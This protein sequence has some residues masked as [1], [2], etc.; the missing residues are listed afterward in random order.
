MVKPQRVLCRVTT[1]SCRAVDDG[2]DG[3]AGRALQEVQRLARRRRIPVHHREWALQVHSSAGCFTPC[4]V[5]PH[6]L[7][8]TAQHLLVVSN[9]SP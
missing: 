5:V 2:T 6:D 7:T 3:E 8:A 4:H 9:S 1:F